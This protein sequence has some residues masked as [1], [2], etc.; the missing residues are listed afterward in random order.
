M[1]HRPSSSNNNSNSRSV[2]NE[3]K[4]RKTDRDRQN[5]QTEQTHHVTRL[6]EVIAVDQNLPSPAI[7]PADRSAKVKHHSSLVRLLSLLSRG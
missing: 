5:K 6:V 1:S 3:K 4:D 2:N 7:S